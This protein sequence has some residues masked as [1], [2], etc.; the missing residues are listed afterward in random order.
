MN[1]INKVIRHF[2][3]YKYIYSLKY[4]PFEKQEHYENLPSV[5]KYLEQYRENFHSTSRYDYDFQ[6]E[7]LDATIIVPAYNCAAYISECINSLLAQQT[8]YSYEVI[9]VN[10][11]STDDTKKIL[12]TFKDEKLI[13]INKENSGVS[14]ARNQGLFEARGQYLIFCDSDDWMPKNAVESLLNEAI[15]LKADI[16]EGNY[17][18]INQNGELLRVKKHGKYKKMNTWGVP[19]GKCIKRDLFSNTIFPIHYLFEDSI[20]HHIILPKAEKVIWIKNIVYYYRLNNNS[21]TVRAKDDIKSIDSLW[22]TK[23]LFE[24]HCMENL[25][26]NSEYYGYILNVIRLTYWRTNH[27]SIDIQ[28]A[29]FLYFKIFISDFKDKQFDLN[30]DQKNINKILKYGDFEDYKNYIEKT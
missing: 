23:Q 15:K 1:I 30:T 29:I 28:K 12:N 6:N 4:V 10:D 22:I 7:T 18:Y 26:V 2:G 17:Q 24:E 16:V 14:S 3:V 21:I 11:G 19:W 9:V 20:I 5:E 13:V 8:K 27:L 25:P